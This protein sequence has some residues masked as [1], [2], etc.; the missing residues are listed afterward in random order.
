MFLCFYS[1][2]GGDQAVAALLMR[3]FEE[4]YSQYSFLF[5]LLLGWLTFHC[6]LAE[7]QLLRQQAGDKLLM[8]F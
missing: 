7:G 1:K 6:A 2:E 3:L 4:I 5:Q 8:L